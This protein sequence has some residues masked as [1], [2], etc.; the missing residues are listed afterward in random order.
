M[1]EGLLAQSCT[2]SLQH[3]VAYSMYGL[4]GVFTSVTYPWR[5]PRRSHMCNIAPT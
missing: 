4:L 3:A 5:I 2:K 1:P